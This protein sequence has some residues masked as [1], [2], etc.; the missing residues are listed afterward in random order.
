M[1]PEPHT[2]PSTIERERDHRKQTRELKV[3]VAPKRHSGAIVHGNQFGFLDCVYGDPAVIRRTSLLCM[4]PEGEIHQRDVP[5]LCIPRTVRRRITTSRKIIRAKIW[6]ILRLR[7]YMEHK[8]RSQYGLVSRMD[9]GGE[10]HQRDVPVLCIP[11][12]VRRR[13]TTSRRIIRGTSSDRPYEEGRRNED[14]P[15][16]AGR[17]R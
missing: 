7:L 8:R 3:A 6:L 17:F 15:V 12:T 5:V 10:I 1:S 9:P 13:I 4:D 14:N 16:L 11:R 2:A